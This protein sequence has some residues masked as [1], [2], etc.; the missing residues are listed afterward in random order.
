MIPSQAY[1]YNDQLSPT[2]ASFS[3]WPLEAVRRQGPSG[4]DHALEVIRQ[5]AIYKQPG[6]AL[7]RAVFCG[8]WT[9]DCQG[10]LCYWKS[11]RQCPLVSGFSLRCPACNFIWSGN[12]F[13][14]SSCSLLPGCHDHVAACM[15]WPLQK[16]IMPVL[17]SYVLSMQLEEAEDWED[18]IDEILLRFQ[19]ETGRRPL[20]D[21]CFY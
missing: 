15:S 10:K 9:Y 20:Y 6:K 4:A 12:S 18:E 8:Y 1:A 21:I 11:W 5:Y 2:W 17:K 13:A 14:C 7:F 19:G 3:D 16:Q